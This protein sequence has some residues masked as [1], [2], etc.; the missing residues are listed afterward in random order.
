MKPKFGIGDVV[1]LKDRYVTHHV[2]GRTYRMPVWGVVKEVIY[3]SDRVA[4]RLYNY[5]T[6]YPEEILTA[7]FDDTQT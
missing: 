7:N 2:G 6:E 4:Y 5:L 3:Y 1:R